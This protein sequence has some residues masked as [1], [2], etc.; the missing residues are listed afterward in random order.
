MDS[1][2]SLWPVLVTG[3]IIVGISWYVIV[4]YSPG[5]KRARTKQT[6]QKKRPADKIT[7]TIEQDLAGARTIEEAFAIGKEEL[8][9][10][11]LQ[12]Q[13]SRHE[14]RRKE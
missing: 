4:R 5:R 2:A 14:K 13:Q 12:I 1:L 11:K 3:A 10:I 6:R 9:N 8:N 7:A